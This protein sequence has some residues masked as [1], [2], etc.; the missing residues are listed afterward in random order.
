MVPI[1]GTNGTVVSNLLFYAITINVLN[2]S[3]N[4]LWWKGE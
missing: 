3:N 1:I 2:Y 4:K